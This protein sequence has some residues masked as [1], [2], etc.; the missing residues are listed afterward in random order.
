M[1]V[2]NRAIL[3]TCKLR[4]VRISCLR[5]LNDT[6]EMNFAILCF[7]VMAQKWD[8]WFVFD[9]TVHTIS[10]IWN[11]R[12]VESSSSVLVPSSWTNGTTLR[13]TS[14]ESYNTLAAFD[15]LHS[16]TSTHECLSDTR[17]RLFGSSL[18]RIL[19]IVCPALDIACSAC[20]CYWDGEK[21]PGKCRQQRNIGTVVP[22]PV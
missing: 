7:E 3:C 20:L 10:K 18:F 5:F 1:Y 4:R 9:E 16:S 17:S 6:I 21:G 19:V 8:L 2:D 22:P 13:S 12:D 15:I 11:P 14:I